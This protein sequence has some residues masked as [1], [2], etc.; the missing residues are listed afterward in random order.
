MH[1]TGP[2]KG[3]P[4]S[5]APVDAASP[6][7]EPQ[8]EN[9]APGVQSQTQPPSLLST[10]GQPEGATTDA[11]L[12]SA[13]TLQAAATT[14]SDG[15][16]A[17]TEERGP[18]LTGLREQAEHGDAQAQFD[19]GREFIQGNAVHQ[20]MAQAFEW[21]SK[22]AQQGHAEA[23][24]S[25]GLMYYLGSGVEDDNEQAFKW[26]SKA[27]EQGN[28]RAQAHV[29]YMYLNGEHVQKNPQQA[30]EW[31]SKAAQ[32]GDILAHRSLSDM[33]REGIYVKK[34]IEMAAQHLL[35]VDGWGQPDVK[36]LDLTSCK[37]NDEMVT[38][39]AS[40]MQNDQTIEKL[41]LS[42]NDITDVGA[43]A[44]A[45]MLE[46]NT[47]LR[48]LNLHYNPIGQPGLKAI[49]DAMRS[50]TTLQEVLVT[51]PAEASEDMRLQVSVIESQTANNK[52]IEGKR[53]EQQS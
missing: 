22:A 39:I 19:L 43:A 51:L 17:M 21:I 15:G 11:R 37:I 35:R 10:Q 27:A 5:S 44:L 24:A 6:T 9:A 50:N 29:G 12:T 34:D 32:Q 26:L 42:G 18:D 33:Y 25:L 2:K 38:A 45:R 46:Q 52:R 1:P 49:A 53:T 4:L 23:Q 41:S 3:D 36:E 47:R 16:V 14:G 28:S 13:P 30:F 8:Q 40:L 20:D 31:F 48:L 7:Q